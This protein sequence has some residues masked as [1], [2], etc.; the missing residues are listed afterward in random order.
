[1]DLKIAWLYHDIL[2][3]YGDRGNILALSYR[4]HSRNINIDIDQVSLG[5]PLKP[6][7]YDLI[8]SGG[9]QDRQQLLAAADLADKKE[10][11]KKY[12]DRGVPM[13]LIC[14]SY[15]LFGHYFLTSE[16]NKLSGISIFDCITVASQQR[17]IGNT[18]ISLNPN[19]SD[20]AGF[21]NMSDKLVGFENH[22]GN[23]FIQKLNLQNARYKT[24]PLGRVIK[25]AGNNG[26]DKT[27][28]A[29][30]K[31]VFGTYLH[32]SVLPKNPHFCDFLI[33]K[34]LEQKYKRKI[35]LKNLK[36]DE[37]WQ[38]HRRCQKLAR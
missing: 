29:V 33:T 3:T 18:V 17:K 25:G 28:G 16:K 20:L 13:L 11:L 36:D 35:T 30:Y 1:M 38:A 5:Q 4:C 37:E 21:Q 14:G 34:A 23:T 10:T 27:E 6:G 26:Q 19:L 12:A 8:F 22:S 9:G 15:Q 7:Y 32:G 2:N 24:L 31:N